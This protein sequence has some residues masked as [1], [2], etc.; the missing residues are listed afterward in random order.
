MERMKTFAIYALVII[1]FFIFSNVMIEI[2][3][4]TSYKPITSYVTKKDM[5]EIEMTQAKATYV[6]GYIGGN[7]K[8][9]NANEETKYIKIDFYSPRN[10]VL[11]TK[12]I[13]LKNWKQGEMCE[14]KIGFRYT[15]VAYAKIDVIDYIQEEV[16]KEQFMS[17]DMKFTILLT[18][19]VFLCFFG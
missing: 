14:F 10:I 2:A 8:N 11:G 13:E 1:L 12:Y 19:V 6:N 3:I 9:I 5:Y 15:D 7:I 17:D 4:K 18:T 16:T